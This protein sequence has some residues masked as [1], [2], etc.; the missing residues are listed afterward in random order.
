MSASR[1]FQTRQRLIRVSIPI[2]RIPVPERVDGRGGRAH[3]VRD[4]D[5]GAHRR[6]PLGRRLS[7]EDLP[8]GDD[9]R[10]RRHSGAAGRASARRRSLPGDRRRIRQSLAARVDRLERNL[11]APARQVTFNSILML[12]SSMLNTFSMCVRVF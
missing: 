11:R 4:R 7:Q 8:D 9:S 2:R 3:Q 1:P 12:Q 10:G 6:A 5:A